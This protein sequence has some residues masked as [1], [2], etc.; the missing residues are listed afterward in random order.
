VIQ[1]YK[2]NPKTSF[3]KYMHKR[4]SDKVL[5]TYGQQKDLNF[6][7]IFGAGLTKLGLMCGHITQSDADE[8]Y[9]TH[10]WDHPKLAI[11]KEIKKAYEEE[12]PEVVELMALSMHLA[13][14]G[15]DS[16]CNLRD[17]LHRSYDHRG[18]VR[19][20]KGRRMRFPTGQRLHKAFNGIDQ[21]TEADYMKTKLV[22]LHKARHETGFVLRVTNHDEVVGDGDRQVAQRIDELLNKQSF[23]E[24]RVPLTWETS[25]GPNWADVKGL[26]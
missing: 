2:D 11:T 14:P 1:E 8:I 10:N 9:A 24:M 5:L 3:H 21:G 19:T 15:C 6:A 4:L 17:N 20:L 18:Y 26:E 7:Y 25:M 13:K 22:E 12:I 16:D 23:P